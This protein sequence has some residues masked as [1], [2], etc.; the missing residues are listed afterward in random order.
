MLALTLSARVRIVPVK[1]F[2]VLVKLPMFAISSLLLLSA[3]PI[4]AL[5]AI[6]KPKGERAAP[7][8]AGAHA[9]DGADRLFCFA[10]KLRGGV[11]TRPVAWGDRGG[12]K[13]RAKPLRQRSGRHRPPTPPENPP[14]PRPPGAEA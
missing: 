4:A 2:A 9:K 14:Q 10:R 11:P 13:S 5:M 7:F 1:P 8:R 3:A 12:G 6:G